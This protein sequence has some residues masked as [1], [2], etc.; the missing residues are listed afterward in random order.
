[1]KILSKQDFAYSVGTITGFTDQTS[2]ELI[3]KSLLGGVTASN[4]TVRLGLK[5]TQQ[6]Q[7]LD[8]TLYPQDGSCGWTASGT[9]TYTQVSLTVCPEKVNEALCPDD[10]YSTY[11]SLLLTK[12][13]TEEDVPF[14]EQ[15]MD[16]KVA[17]IQQ[18][19]EQKLWTATTDG[20]DC[21][22]G[23]KTTIAS[24]QTGVAAVAGTAFDVTKDYGTAGNP[25]YEVD[26]L[27]NGLSDD[28][29]SRDD[30]IVWMS[31][32]NFRKYVQALTKANYFQNYINGT[33]ITD[34]MHAIHP[35][36]NIKVL[37]TIGLN[38]V[39]SVVIGPAGFMF[40]GFDLL[41]DNDSMDMW[42]SKDNDEV[43]IR[44]NYN[45][46]STVKTFSDI[47]YFAVN[48]L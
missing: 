8:S 4:I 6:I 18:R 44:A 22:D 42:Y 2:T 1:M 5:G 47:N 25:I 37:P 14:A 7:V 41:S 28:A 35:N 27:I 3:T 30:L 20:G 39:N 21:F 48:S 40:A 11:Q 34:Q 16:L 29:M 43:R 15:I 23:F 12:G 38:G 32:A 13:Q 24:G 45:Y 9:T 26:L 19:I 17:Q 31:H 33:S 36:T 10:L 46:G